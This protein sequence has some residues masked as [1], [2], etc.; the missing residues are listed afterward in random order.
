MLG[1]CGLRCGNYQRRENRADEALRR[2]SIR[3]VHGAQR[4]KRDAR[5]ILDQLFGVVCLCFR[6]LNKNDIARFDLQVNS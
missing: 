3:F 5:V 2:E 4:C 1:T 6:R